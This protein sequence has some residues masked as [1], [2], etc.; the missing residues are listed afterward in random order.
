MKYFLLLV[1]IV[2]SLQLLTAQ[3]IGST[4]E[5]QLENLTNAEEVEIE[6]DF[7]IV[8]LDQFRKHPINLNNTTADELKQLLLLSDLQ[9]DNLLNYRRLLGKLVSLYELQAVP[10]WDSATI[11][12][13]LPFIRVADDGLPI[14]KLQD[15]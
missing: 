7:Y 14:D 3:E 13:I 11:Q 5:Q 2:V 6:D 4:G 15:G 9:I 12:K 10:S 8:K 1:M